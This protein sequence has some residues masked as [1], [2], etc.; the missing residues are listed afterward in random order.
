MKRLV[1]ATAGGAELGV[2]HVMRAASLAREAVS[3]GIGTVMHV[4]GEESVRRAAAREIPEVP[5]EPWDGVSHVAANARGLLIDAPH[6][7]APVV[8]AARAAGVP[9]TVL[10]RLDTLETA[11]WTVLP[12]LHAEPRA[13][14]R[15][16]HGADWCVLEPRRLGLPVPSFPGERDLLLVAFGGADAGGWTRQVAEALPAPPPS[17]LR[18]VF[19]VGPAAPPE[20]ADELAPYG[21][22]LR[23]PSRRELFAWMGRARL[24]VCGFGVTL[25][26]L[27]ALGTPA[28]VFARDDADA[29]AALRLS[30]RGIGR[31]VGPAGGFDADAFRDALVDAL[32]DDWPERTHRQGLQALGDGAGA[33]RILELTLG[34]R[35]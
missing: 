16:R 12:V 7:I 13:H 2:G 9:T 27:A 22:V 33:G 17:G 34:D 10:D 30:E 23:A 3:H 4:A 20:R 24:A 35:R 31:L 6:P 26:E 29:T 11:S 14:P 21:E 18:P 32:H 15:L 8:D 5:I 28:L 1:I 19:A 25:Y